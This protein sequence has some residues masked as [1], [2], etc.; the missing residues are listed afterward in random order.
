[1]L[2]LLCLLSL[3]SLSHLVLLLR[4]RLWGLLLTLSRIKVRRK[5]VLS[6]LLMRLLTLRRQLLLL[7]SRQSTL[8]SERRNRRIAW[9]RLRGLRL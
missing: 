4:R 1:M 3:L 2:R 9:L 5:T 7:V 8:V 6:I